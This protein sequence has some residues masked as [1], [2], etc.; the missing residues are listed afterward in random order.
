M[1]RAA[2]TAVA[3]VAGLAVAAPA[4]ARTVW[5]CKPGR[6]HDPCAPSLTT[7]RF[8]PA[9]AAVRVIKVKRA[10]HP[11]IDCFYV[12]PTVSDQQ[13]LAATLRVDPVERSIALYQ[14]ARYSQLCRVWAPMYRQI[15]IRGLLQP[16]TVTP[17]MRAR[18]YRDV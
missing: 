7:T 1:R 8:T 9:G 2:L 16:K 6:R 4:H 13:R 15:T 17:A 3:L 12:Y 14:A 11:R 10:R 5:L 18:A